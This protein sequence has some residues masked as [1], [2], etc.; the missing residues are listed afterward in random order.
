M[1]P[2]K[3]APRV[4]CGDTQGLCQ[5]MAPKM[6]KPRAALANIGNKGRA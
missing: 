5:Q 4:T 1:E 6:K 2:K 3:K